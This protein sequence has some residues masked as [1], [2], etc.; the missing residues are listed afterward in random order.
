M[1]KAS[2]GA[3]LLSI[4]GALFKSINRA[5]PYLGRGCIVIF[6]VVS[7]ITTG[8]S[9]STTWSAASSVV[10]STDIVDRTQKGDRLPL[11]RN[12][13]TLPLK[14]IEQ[15]GF[16]NQGLPVGCEAVGSPLAHAS[17]AHVAGRC[18]S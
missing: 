2:G 11:H 5:F 12:T 9:A 4:P 10:P 7:I 6:S 14:R 13:V 15:T 8:L 16:S 18:L 3:M 1:S 17:L